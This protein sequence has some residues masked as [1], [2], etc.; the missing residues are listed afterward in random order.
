MKRVDP[1]TEHAILRHHLVDKWPIGTV[2][3]QLGVHHDVVRRVLRQR[4][5]SPQAAIVVRPRML[6][7]YLPFI[8]QTLEKYPRLH[9]SRLYLMARERGYPGSEGHF[10]RLIAQLRPRPV[11]EPFA[12]LSMPKG[13]QAQ[14]DWAHFGKVQVGRALRP[15]CA[16]ILTLSWSRMC[17]VQFFHDM[18]RPS[19]L[20]GHVDAFA[21]FEGVPR[22]VLYDN[23][24][25]ACIER[26][27]R[28]ARFNDSLLEMASYYGFEPLLANPGRGNEKGRVERTVRYVRTSFFA[29]RSFRD[30]HDLNAQARTWCLEVAGTRRWQDDD[31]TTVGAQ[32]ADERGQLIP[33]PDTPFEALERIEARVG[34]T[35][36][37][38]FDTND[39][40]LPCE[41]TRRVVT[42]LVEP[43]RVRIVVEGSVIAEH[44][45]SYDRRVSV[46]DPEHLQ[47]LRAFKARAQ[48]GSGTHRLTRA[49]PAAATM[50]ERAAERGHNLGSL[51]S[52]LLDLLDMYGADAMQRAVTEVN[53]SDRVGAN[54]VRLSLEAHYRVQGRTP[55]RP[56]LIRNPRARDVTVTP[57][58]LT[59]YDRLTEDDN[60]QDN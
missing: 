45:R 24:K 38:R 60:E 56:V 49:A 39:Y 51:V 15:L 5:L 25:S 17:F 20:R 29:A 12:R 28:T 54:H 22:Q 10:R 34:R 11:P 48:R 2:A 36:Y 33:L 55:P 27:G 7:A 41:H 8:Q 23:L 31:R 46:E 47:G 3:S 6:D 32:F 1:E 9:A 21:F 40:S 13:E 58:D 14:M 19:F 53:D 43:D 44:R 30:I 52:A 57:A 16:H 37:V 18:E 26:Q 35:P 4:G 50:V 59:A 42:L